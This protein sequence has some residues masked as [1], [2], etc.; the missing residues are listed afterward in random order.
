MK[1]IES[2]EVIDREKR[3]AIDPM[4]LEIW[5][6]LYNDLTD[7]EKNCFFYSLKEREYK[8]NQFVFRQGEV[9]SSLY[10]IRRGKL[11]LISVKGGEKHPIRA[12]ST[13]HIAGRESFF[14]HTVCRAS[15]VTLTD[16]TLECLGID[17]FEK[18]E[19]DC[20]TLESKLYEYCFGKGKTHELLAKKGFNQREHKRFA[21]SC[22]AIAQ[23]L[24][25]DG[26]PVGQPFKVDL[27]DISAGGLSFFVR[28]PRKEVA[29]KL[30]GQQIRL[31]FYL[32]SDGER[33]ELEQLGKIVALRNHPFGD[34]SVHVKFDKMMSERE[35]LDLERSCGNP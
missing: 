25:A 15:L 6:E 21:I 24:K 3:R 20:P 27:A 28:I 12:L 9:N 17:I 16:V 29:R 26:S 11:A 5:S 22:K 31:R 35:I 8:A 1:Y 34:H 7:L 19:Q 13:G 4:H 2:A 14:F 30:L 32:P 33:R 18:W 10:F 23:L